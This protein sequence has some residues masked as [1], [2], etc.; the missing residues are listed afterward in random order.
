MSQNE[1]KKKTNNDGFRDMPEV[2]IDPDDREDLKGNNHKKIY[3]IVILM[4]IILALAGAC[5]SLIQDMFSSRDEKIVEEPRKEVGKAVESKEKEKVDETKPEFI[6]FNDHVVVELNALDVDF[7][8]Y[9]LAIDDGKQADVTTTGDVN[10]AAEGEYTIQVTA[11]DEA[12]NKTEQ[13]ATVQVISEDTMATGI[14]FSCYLDGSIPL[15]AGTKE[16]VLANVIYYYYQEVPAE[17][18]DEIQKLGIDVS[19]YATSN[20]WHPS[21]M[22]V[23]AV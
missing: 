16:R 15:E 3:V 19:D 11:E 6:G 14:E 22:T 2:R 12:G 4:V 17:I 20:T 5:Y 1:S 23:P 8:K 13:D 18:S 10:L 7:S 21:M 9:F